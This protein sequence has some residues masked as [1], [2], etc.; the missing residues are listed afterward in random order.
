MEK[1]QD[2]EVGDE[3]PCCTRTNEGLLTSLEYVH[4]HL[5]SRVH[6][7]VISILILFHPSYTFPFYSECSPPMPKIIGHVVILCQAVFS[8]CFLADQSDR[9]ERLRIRGGADAA[10]GTTHIRNVDAI[11]LPIARVN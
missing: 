2:S 1:I 8:A 11:L 3:V 7:S 9:V 6:S 10:W 5:L 4:G